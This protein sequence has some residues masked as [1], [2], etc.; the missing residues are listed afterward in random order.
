L[1]VSFRWTHEKKTPAT[2]Y[3]VSEQLRRN[4]E[5]LLRERAEIEQYV[6]DRNAAANQHSTGKTDSPA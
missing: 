1:P 5:Y 2:D 4:H 3:E 6:R